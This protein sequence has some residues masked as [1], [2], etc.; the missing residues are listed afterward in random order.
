VIFDT[1]STGGTFINGRRIGQSVLYP[2]DVI[3]L[4]GVIFI[5]SQEL[6]AKPG[7]VKI[8]ELGSPFAADRPTAVMRRGELKPIDRTAEKDLPELPKTGP[9]P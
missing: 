3:S 1:N 9:L 2:G 7:E 8:I 6:P 5:Y 4:A